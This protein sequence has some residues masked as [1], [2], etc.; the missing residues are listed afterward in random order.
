MAAQRSRRST[1]GNRMGRL[2]QDEVDDEFYK[3]AFGGFEEE[4]NDDEF[5]S[6]DSDSSDSVD[7]DF[8]NPE[9]ERAEPTS[10]NEE[11]EKRPKKKPVPSYMRKKASGP[12]KKAPPPKKRKPKQRVVVMGDDTDDEDDDD[13]EHTGR[14]RKSARTSVKENS[15]ALKVRLEIDEV[16]RQSRTPKRRIVAVKMSQEELLEQAKVT[17]E[18]NLASLNVY[19]QLEEERKRAKSIVKKHCIEGPYIRSQSVSM[20]DDVEGE[21]SLPPHSRNFVT[22]CDVDTFDYFPRDKPVEVSRDHCVVTGLPARYKDPLTG[23]PYANVQA[24]RIIRQYHSRGSLG[25]LVNK[26]RIRNMTTAARHFKTNTNTV[27]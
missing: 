11:T 8:D 4:P 15:E 10:D 26:D 14:R 7:S 19:I 16:K 27:I 3:T 5:D 18:E 13:R 20:G 17:E 2:V 9:N 6:N 12:P 1:A 24:F 21:E 23:M 25:V 22:F